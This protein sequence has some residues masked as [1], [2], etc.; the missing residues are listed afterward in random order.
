MDWPNLGEKKEQGVTG[1]KAQLNHLHR[2]LMKKL[3][4]PASIRACYKN[5]E[6]SK[7]V[8][9]SASE[10]THFKAFSDINKFQ[11]LSETS[12]VKFKDVLKIHRS[13]NP[14]HQQD[15]SQI[16]VDLSCDGVADSKSSSI[17]MDMYTI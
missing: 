11:K 4:P 5:L 3:C 6:S 17:S 1:K 10:V 9:P 2:K 7:V 15:V 8:I 14:Q 16:T 13:I 12:S